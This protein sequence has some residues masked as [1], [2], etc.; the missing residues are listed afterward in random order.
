MARGDRAGRRQYW[1]RRALHI[2]LRKRN[3][4]FGH[5]QYVG[6]GHYQH[7]GCDRCWLSF[8]NRQVSNVFDYNKDGF[9]NSSDENSARSS[10]VIIKFIKIA[11]STP[12]AR[13][14]Q[15][16]VVAVIPA[17]T[18]ATTAGARVAAIREWQAAWRVCWEASSPARSRHYDSICWRA[19]WTA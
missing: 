5:G 19:S 11:A 8:G 12:L 7:D 9:V 14:A 10:G 13:S 3:W 18:P 4:Q 6:V 17:V 1:S 2:L 16:L 15:A